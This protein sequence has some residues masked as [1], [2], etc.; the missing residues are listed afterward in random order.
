MFDNIFGKKEEEKTIEIAPTTGT[1][2]S[3]V[4]TVDLV[5]KPTENKE[6]VCDE[7]CGHTHN[8]EQPQDHTEPPP[9]TYKEARALKRSKYETIANNFKTAY[10]LRN[11]RTGQIVEIRAAS[12]C[13]ACNIIG[14]KTNKV[15]LLSE[16]VI[17][18]ESQPKE[19]K[20]EETVTETSSSTT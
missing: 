6:H 15:E 4:E 10:V 2:E 3:G 20:R 8:Q 14:W 5:I 13:H 19:V 12:S 1:I 18:S 7:H 11:K 17:T 9:L 16:R